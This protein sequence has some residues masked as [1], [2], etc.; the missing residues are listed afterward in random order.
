MWLDGIGFATPL[1]D[2]TKSKHR[3]QGRLWRHAAGPQG[4][5]LGHLLRRHGHRPA[6][7][8]K[9][10]A[11]FYIQWAS[12]KENQIAMLKAGAGAPGRK[13]PF[14]DPEGT[15]SKTFAEGLFRLHG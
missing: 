8:K 7:K 15:K 3:R 5:S 10:P 11:W 1:E 4:A 13:S 12:N 2:P 9:G 6:S 14:K